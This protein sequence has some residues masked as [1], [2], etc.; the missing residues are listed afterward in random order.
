MARTKKSTPKP[1]PS[2]AVRDWIIRGV[3]FGVLAVLLVPALQEFQAKR[4]ATGTAEAWRA[5]M[6]AKPVDSELTKSEFGKV[7]VQGRPTMVS[8]PAE[9]NSLAAKTVET[10]TW[11]G[12][13]RQYVVKVYFGL[14][15]DPTV[16]AI[17][18]PGADAEPLN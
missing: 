18:G 16:E 17:T 6:K 5:A 13:F 11:S 2:T 3:V 12:V 4:A 15:T 8:G 14:G 10:Y 9:T 1:K 7:L